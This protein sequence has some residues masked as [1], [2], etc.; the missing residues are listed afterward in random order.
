MTEQERYLM[1]LRN[2]VAKQ[3]QYYNAALKGMNLPQVVKDGG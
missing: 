3:G 1:R 2:S